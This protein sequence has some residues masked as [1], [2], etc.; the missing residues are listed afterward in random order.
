MRL[1][2]HHEPPADAVHVQTRRSTSGRHS[3][4]NIQHSAFSIQLDAAEKR[5]QR[6]AVRA[7]ERVERGDRVAGLAAVQEYRIED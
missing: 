5:E 4:F 2:Y 3:T 1:A 7:A 6:L